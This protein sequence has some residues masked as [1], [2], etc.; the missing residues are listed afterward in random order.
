MTGRLQPGDIPVMVRA[1][2]IAAE[3]HRYLNACTDEVGRLLQVLA[4]QHP[5]ERIGEIGAGYGV[6]TAWIASGLATGT[7]LLTIDNNP[8]AVEA[9][10]RQFGDHGLI[11]V[12]EGDWQFILQHGPFNMLY[13]NVDEA[14]DAGAEDVID[15]LAI[16][17][18][19][20]IND[21]TP[22]EYQPEATRDTP[23]PVRERW[24]EN[25]RLRGVEILVT[26]KSAVILATRWR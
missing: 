14:K 4:G 13:I 11:E 10:R 25:P 22:Y 12:F 15:A 17:G 6:G 24:L 23:D 19:A 1:A 3:R 2:R 18:L 20:V 8:D 7:R 5:N 21:L 9:I 26:P 16:G